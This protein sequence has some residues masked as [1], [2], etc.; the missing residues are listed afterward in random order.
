ML[1]KIAELSVTS[2]VSSARSTKS[3]MPTYESQ[4]LIWDQL[5]QMAPIKTRIPQEHDMTS[6]I[7]HIAAQ[8]DTN[9]AAPEFVNGQTTRNLVR[10]CE[11]VLKSTLKTSAFDADTHA[12]VILQNQRNLGQRLRAC[13]KC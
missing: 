4:R 9:F 1:C 6:W 5:T 10:I 11:L 8:S 7:S 12:L 3:A 13:P 2:E